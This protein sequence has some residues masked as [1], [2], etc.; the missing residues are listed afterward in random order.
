MCNFLLNFS[1]PSFQ[2]DGQ[3]FL[4]S[5]DSMFIKTSPF[6][7]QKVIH[8]CCVNFASNTKLRKLWQLLL[9]SASFLNQGHCSIVTGYTLLGCFLML[10]MIRVNLKD[11]S[12]LKTLK[13]LLHSSTSTLDEEYYL[14]L[15][16][17]LFTNSL[18]ISF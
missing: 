8:N 14:L 10:C 5:F 11:A 7:R 1:F 2:L 17:S 12:V 4:I 18:K 13:Q 16:G 3:C 15:F 9:S 6:Y